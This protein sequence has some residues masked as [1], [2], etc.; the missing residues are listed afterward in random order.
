MEF[1]IILIGGGL[2]AWY[3]AHRIYKEA[4]PRPWW[5]AFLKHP[6]R[7]KAYS[8]LLY[9]SILDTFVRLYPKYDRTI[10]MPPVDTGKMRPSRFPQ[11]EYPIQIVNKTGYF[12]HDP[13]TG[14]SIITVKDE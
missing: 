14:E 13:Q 6:E 4:Q 2:L 11:G 8:D 10:K 12:T 5:D 9:G 3:I 7:F 1:M